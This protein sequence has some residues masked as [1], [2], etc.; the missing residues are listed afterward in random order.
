MDS[1]RKDERRN[2]FNRRKKGKKH[3]EKFNRKP[4]GADPVFF[5]PTANTP[6][7]MPVRSIENILA[8]AVTT[9]D[10]RPELIHAIKKTG[11]IVTKDNQQYL[12]KEELN[13]WNKAINEGECNEG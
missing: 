4:T 7:P 11:R 10:L 6:Q 1:N 2:R 5:D 13:E 3:N 12:T 9:A 8:E